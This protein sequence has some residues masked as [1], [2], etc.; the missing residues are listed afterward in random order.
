MFG[1]FV[2][3]H[4]GLTFIQG[5][6]ST[7]Q[8]AYWARAEY[9]QAAQRNGFR[10]RRGLVATFLKCRGVKLEVWVERLNEDEAV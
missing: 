7:Q 6:Y 9:I 5:P 8:E 1:L 3:R 10:A 2:K 4:E